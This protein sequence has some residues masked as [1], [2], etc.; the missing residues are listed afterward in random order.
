MTWSLARECGRECQV[1]VGLKE[2]FDL[3]CRFCFFT[4]RIYSRIT[5][6]IKS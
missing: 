6:V 1:G 5:Y 2:D 3:T 4:S